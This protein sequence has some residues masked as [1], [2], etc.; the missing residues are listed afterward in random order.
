MGTFFHLLPESWIHALGWTMVHSLWQGAL[1]AL[2]LSGFRAVS[3]RLAPQYRYVAGLS[4]MIGLFAVSVTTFC[5]QLE[6][7][8]IAGDGI[9]ISLSGVIEEEQVSFVSNLTAFLNRQLPFLVI[10]WIAGLLFFTLR[11]AGGYWYV[12][13]LRRT[14]M[15]LSEA[16]WQVRMEQIASRLK[17]RRP[18]GLMESLQVS[19]PLVIGHLKPLILLPV[20][21]LNQLSLAEVDAILA[22]ELA[23]IRRHDFLINLIQALLETL[24][25]FNPAAWYI[26][27]GIRAERENCCDDWAIEVCGSSLTYVHALVR[28]QERAVS[29][30]QFALSMAGGGKPLLQR[31]RRILNQPNHKKTIMERFTATLLLLAAAAVF[32][33]SASRPDVGTAQGDAAQPVLVSLERS[34]DS[35]PPAPA[36]V[37]KERIVKQKGDQVMELTVENGEIVEFKVDGEVISPEEFSRYQKDIDAMQADLKMPPPPP[38]PPPAPPSGIGVPPPPPPPPPAPRAP[39]ELR[40][41]KEIEVTTD[42]DDEGKVMIWKDEDGNL[43][44]VYIDDADAPALIDNPDEEE[45]IILR[46]GEEPAII[47]GDKLRFQ[48]ENEDK[49]RAIEERERAMEDEH[50]AREEAHRELEIRQRD[51]QQ[52]ME[53]SMRNREEAIRKRQFEAQDIQRGAAPFPERGSLKSAIERE[54]RRDGYIRPDGTYEFELSGKKLVINGKKESEVIFN[55]YRNIYEKQ[56]GIELS[57][58]SRIEI[59]E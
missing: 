45:V 4:A 3:G 6:T 38:P 58:D 12:H 26:S 2:L 11:T 49:F 57:K 21:L 28:L 40:I 46:E 10:A 32:S 41:E 16:H 43:T 53:T 44:K 39:R 14:G 56:T 35:I 1:L 34:L 24:F 48:R 17:I 52:E 37:E 19:V 59:D 18:V 33:I 13:Q 36:L 31:V 22:H 29:M 51:I 15:T 27:S 5:L 8:A 55:K 9:L 25:Y 30:P 42:G 23:H 47:K 20:G 50:R 54:L 7:E